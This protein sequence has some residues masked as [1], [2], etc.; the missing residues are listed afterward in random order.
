MVKKCFF[1]LVAICMIS[2]TGCAPVVKGVTKIFPFLK[3]LV[4]FADDV[5]RPVIKKNGVQIGVMAVRLAILEK[6]KLFEA[7]E[8]ARQVTE[9]V[10][11]LISQLPQNVSIKSRA[12]IEKK[13]DLN[14]AKLNNEIKNIDQKVNSE[15]AYKQT[16]ERI[17][18][19]TKENE[20]IAHRLKN[21]G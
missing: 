12:F 18:R 11:E 16:R 10:G 8:E 21:I 14:S 19:I 5:A 15:Q 9:K 3:S 13:F 6:D 20:A 2:Q 4:G 1:A 7:I 17:E